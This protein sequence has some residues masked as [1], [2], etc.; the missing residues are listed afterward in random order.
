[1]KSSVARSFSLIVFF[2]VAASGAAA[3]AAADKAVT[4]VWTAA[5]VSIDGSDA[6]WQGVPLV[7]DE[8]SGAEFAVRNDGRNLY[9]LFVFRTRK[10]LT[11]LEQTGMRIYFGAAGQNRKDLGLHFR[12]R[13]LTAD[14]L[15]ADLEKKG[16][17]LTDT[18][19]AELKQRPAYQVFIA[20]VI[21]AK[22]LPAPA[23]PAGAAEP[24]FFRAG[25][26]RQKTVYE[27]RAPLSRT[28]QP[29]GLG[30]EP[31]ATIRLGFEWGGLTKEMRA[32]MMA[33]R[34][35]MSTRAGSSDTSMEG[36]LRGGSED[37]DMGSSGPSGFERS[38]AKHAF[39]VDAILASGR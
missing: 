3:G 5:P 25:G 36:A 33:R 4:G 18:R 7:T 11:T 24:P 13:M 30:V 16:E 22:K 14:E 2:A 39:W 32:A 31:G 34:A 1:M 37:A 23:D 20:D 12:R 9:L 10:S 27:F 15:I 29:G 6:D 8:K 28:N 17:V 26:D 38:P 19:R 21:N 35:S